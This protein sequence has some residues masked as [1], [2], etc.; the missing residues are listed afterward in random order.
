MKRE[1]DAQFQEIQR[2]PVKKTTVAHT[3]KMDE[4]YQIMGEFYSGAPRHTSPTK[5]L[6]DQKHAA[7]RHKAKFVEK[8]VL[9]GPY[10]NSSYPYH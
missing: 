5:R 2:S 8:N 9:E 3:L 4:F 7:F 1:Y 10:I 6:I